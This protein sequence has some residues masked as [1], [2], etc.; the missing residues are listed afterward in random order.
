MYVPS[1]ILSTSNLLHNLK[2]IKNIAKNSKIMVMLK[3]NAY[4]HGIRSTAMRLDS[5]VDYIGVARFDEAVALRKVGV[6]APIC[7]MQGVFTKDEVIAAS[8]S[9]FEL[10]VYDFA[11]LDC[12]DIATLKKVNVWLKIDTG[13][14][15][16]GFKPE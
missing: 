15:R 9:N 14:G 3:A 7:I 16:L 1:A 2:E 12:L 13:I 6:K 10:L 11:Q 4:G 8:C 5:S